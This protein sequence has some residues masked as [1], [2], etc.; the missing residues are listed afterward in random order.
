MK[1]QPKLEDVDQSP[2]ERPACH[3]CEEQKKKTTQFFIWAGFRISTKRSVDWG[4]NVVHIQSKYRDMQRLSVLACRDCQV[5]LWRRYHLWYLAGWGIGFVLLAA[6]AITALVITVVNPKLW[7][8]ILVALILLL[9]PTWEV[10]RYGWRICAPSLERSAMEDAIL[11]NVR[12]EFREHGDSFFTNTYY[13][14]VFR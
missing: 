9:F 1:K 3:F 4:K 12:S 6:L 10:I 11:S 14:D 7:A 13:R 2:V 8:M 5:A